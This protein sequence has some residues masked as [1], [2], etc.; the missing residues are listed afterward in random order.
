MSYIVF[1]CIDNVNM[2]LRLLLNNR[3]FEVKIYKYVIEMKEKI[4]MRLTQSYA[5]LTRPNNSFFKTEVC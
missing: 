3:I 1:K 5:T 4:N 2:G